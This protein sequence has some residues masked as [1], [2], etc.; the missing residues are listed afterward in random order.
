MHRP[1]FF[2][3][4]GWMKFLKGLEAEEMA[5]LTTESRNVRMAVAF[6][7]ENAAKNLGLMNDRSERPIII[8][9]LRADPGTS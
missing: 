6:W 2:F 7:G 5:R 9:N 8:C 1:L 3:N 4:G